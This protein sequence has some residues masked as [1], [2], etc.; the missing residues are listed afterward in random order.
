MSN[1][2]LTDIYDLEK[3]RLAGRLAWGALFSVK[4]MKD[5]LGESGKCNTVHRLTLC[6]RGGLGSLQGWCGAPV[7]LLGEYELPLLL[8]IYCHIL[9]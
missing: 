3:T 8:D 6:R 1:I 9:T 2:G 4:L 5:Q 7:V